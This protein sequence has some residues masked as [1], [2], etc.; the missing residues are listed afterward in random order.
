MSG[1]V[2][3]TALKEMTKVFDE[4]LA[5]LSTLQSLA[6]ID[7]EQVDEATLVRESLV[8]L[9]EHY[10][11]EHCAIYLCGNSHFQLAAEVRLDHQ[12]EGEN[13]AVA[14]QPPCF[15]EHFFELFEQCLADGEL[16]LIN[17]C[18]QNL[19][20][21]CGTGSFVCVPI[22]CNGAAVGVLCLSHQDPG[23]FNTW[24]CRF[25]PLFAGI[26]GRVL[27]G[28]RLLGKMEA[29]VRSRTLQL[30]KVLD[31]T[32]K[33][34]DHYRRLAL[35]DELTGTFNRR[36]FFSEAQR[37]LGQ[38]LR[39]GHAYSLLI[40]DFD[41]FKHINDTFGHAS[42]DI[43]LCDVA[44]AL[45]GQ[46]RESDILA[47]VGGEEFAL[48]LPESSSGSASGLGQRLLETVRKLE[49]VFEGETVRMTMSIGAASLE[50]PDE[51]DRESAEQLLD[52]LY[53]QADTAMYKA[54][55]AG[56]DHLTRAGE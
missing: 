56:G 12:L 26:L 21:D 4:M 25:L 48:V 55:K 24:H 36:Y 38:A 1:M 27:S 34:H 5:S 47:R 6:V 3:G 31:E 13:P 35:V 17:D 37:I 11:V 44:R 23:H 54:K 28:H 52:Q 46:I 41:R 2:L 10:G 50:Y 29:E 15:K 14:A 22:N 49:W 16:K 43:I 7:F 20:K 45:L 40:I 19:I 8:V 32:R 18:G 53:S 30:E 39:Y 42:G 33:H 9:V 51:T